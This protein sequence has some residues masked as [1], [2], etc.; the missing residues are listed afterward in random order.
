MSRRD[1]SPVSGRSLIHRVL[2]AIPPASGAIVM[3]SGIVSI[4]LDSGDQQVL[5]AIT[6][7]FAVAV[8][9]VLAVM[10]GLR[11]VH[12]RDR[13]DHEARSPGRV[14]RRRRHRH[15][16]HPVGDQGLRHGRRGAPRGRGSLLGRACRAGPAAL[17][18]PDDRGLLC[19]HRRHRGP[20]SAGSQPG[21]QLPRRLAGQRRG[22]RAGSRTCLL[23][24][25]RRPV[26]PTRPGHRARRP[27]GSRRRTRHLLPRRRPRHPSRSNA[28]ATKRRCTRSSRPARWRSGAWR[29]CRC[30]R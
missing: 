17:E 5:S 16:R 15:P 19:P 6:L 2:D 14:H 25:H 18:D 21:G 9:L 30:S 12:Q 22:R 11:L 26:R 10:L 29:C 13:F 3:A 7:W 28:R 1:R 20:G 27:L 4:D 8:W 23:R 24:L